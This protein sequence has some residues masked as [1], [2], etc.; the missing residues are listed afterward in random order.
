MIS[1]NDRKPRP[2]EKLFYSFIYL[3]SGAVIGL[4]IY[5][6][7]VILIR[8]IPNVTW[9]FLSKAPHPIK[10]TIGILPSLIHTLYIIVFTL[11]LCVPLGV[12]GPS[13]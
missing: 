5:F 6:I 4:V 13:I 2:L 8:G 7:A 12:G 3:L 10:Q 11:L 9:A 1:I